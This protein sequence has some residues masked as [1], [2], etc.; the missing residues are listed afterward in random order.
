M[1]QDGHTLITATIAFSAEAGVSEALS[2]IDTFLNSKNLE[3]EFNSPAT[4][5]RSELSC[6]GNTSICDSQ[7]RVTRSLTSSSNEVVI[8]SLKSNGTVHKQ[9]VLS[10]KRWNA[11]KG[12]WVRFQIEAAQSFGFQLYRKRIKVVNECHHRILMAFLN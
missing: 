7:N 4:N 10:A 6:I 5:Y 12:N 3:Q 1:C 2:E 9:E 11:L 8:Q